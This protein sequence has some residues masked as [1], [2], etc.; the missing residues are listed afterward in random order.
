MSEFVQLQPTTENFL[1]KILN[2][3]KCEILD[4]LSFTKESINE[5]LKKLK[6]VL[7]T[8]NKFKES[9]NM[10]FTLKGNWESIVF[11]S[12]L[13][14]LDEKNKDELTELERKKLSPFFTEDLKKYK[15][16]LN[17]DNN[18]ELT[19][20]LS[21]NEL[22]RIEEGDESEYLRAIELFNI[23][24]DAKKIIIKTEGNDVERMFE[25]RKNLLL[26]NDFVN[27]LGDDTKKIQKVIKYILKKLIKND[28]IKL[29]RKKIE[30]EKIRKDDEIRKWRRSLGLI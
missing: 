5:D 2:N 18:V 17:E 25:Y 9:E 10:V 13:K 21:I 16:E 23:Y 27:F 22:E 12:L 6:N 28:E 19:R 24:L 7:D 30:D 3:L 26:N 29:E 11:I 20:L 14:H 1:S 8:L 4:E 15:S